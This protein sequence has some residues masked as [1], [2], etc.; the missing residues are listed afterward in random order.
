MAVAGRADLHA[1]TTASDGMYTPAEVVRRAKLAGLSAVA[2]TD[3]DTIAGVDEALAEGAKIGISVIPGTE[4]STVTGS[5][6]IHVL[7]YYTDNANPKWRE[8]LEW[9]GSVR[10]RRNDAILHK[11]H[12]LGI[13]ITMDDVREASAGKGGII[14]RPHF[15]QALIRKG[16]VADMSEAFTHYLGTGALA[17]VQVQS[18][19]TAEAIAWIREAGGV[20]V[21]AHPGLYKRDELLEQWVRAGVQGIEVFHSDH[22]EEDAERYRAFAEEHGLLVTGGSDFH[23]ER[24]G[25]SYHGAL[26]SSGVDFCVVDQL[27]RLATSSHDSF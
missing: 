14:G 23:G 9:I 19:T 10:D 16:I 6:D 1:H 8:R 22:N 12:G 27:R 18:V 2:I 17:Y 7:A 24:E 11:L 21:I 20:S 15:A 13:G 25:G 26:G 4:I 3:H 5:A